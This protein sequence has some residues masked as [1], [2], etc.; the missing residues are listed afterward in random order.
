MLIVQATDKQIDAATINMYKTDRRMLCQVYNP[1]GTMNGLPMLLCR[2]F[3]VCLA[4][5]DRMGC[6]TMLISFCVKQ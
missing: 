6:M 1:F 2:C 4:Y 5:F 3:L